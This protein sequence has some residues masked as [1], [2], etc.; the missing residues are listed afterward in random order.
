M[1]VYGLSANVGIG[2]LFLAGFVPGLLLAT[3]Y[4]IYILVRCHLDPTLAPTA[5]EVVART[6]G[7]TE[8]SPNRLLAVVLSIGL[9]GLVMGSIYGGIASVTEAAGVGVFGAL[10]IGRN[11][12]I[13]PTQGAQL[14]H[15]DGGARREMGGARRSDRGV[16]QYRRRPA[17]R[18]LRHLPE[19]HEV[20]RG[21]IGP[22]RPLTAFESLSTWPLF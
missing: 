13:R 20:A 11:P 1:I 4:V 21:L 18:L 16:P 14:R 5:D 19:A 6:G 7:S 17:R 2:D 22:R 3:F 15:A 12:G 9:V 10:I 8:L